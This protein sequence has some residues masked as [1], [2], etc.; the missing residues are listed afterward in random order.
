MAF[1]TAFILPDEHLPSLVSLQVVL[2]PSYAFVQLGQITI[3]RCT[4]VLNELE[5]S[6][7]DSDG[8]W[9]IWG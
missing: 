2:Y 8:Q 3:S 4:R 6:S 9:R 7:M 1:L 5:R